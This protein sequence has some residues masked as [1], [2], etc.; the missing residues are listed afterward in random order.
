MLSFEEANA[1][2]ETAGQSH[3]LQFWAE[4][5]AEERDTILEEIS[6]LQPEELLEHCRAAPAAAS[7]HS[8]ADGRLDERMEPVP[9][10]FF[11]S[12][13]K[14]D[15]E[16]L[17]MWGDEGTRARLDSNIQ[18]NVQYCCN[19]FKSSKACKRLLSS[20][21]LQIS[22]GRVAVL[23]LAGGQGTRLGVSYPKGMYNVGLPSGKTLYQFQAERIQKVQ[24]LAKVKHGCKCTV[25]WYGS[26]SC[27]SHVGILQ[28]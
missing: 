23:L 26:F 1:R 15:K 7:R 4:L 8:S 2:L 19:V 25:P 10:E 12:V 18:K 21:L 6:Q 27:S 13:R 17:Q 5:C 28:L 3:V 22:R 20:G 16:T 24:E 9:P 14:S 11:G